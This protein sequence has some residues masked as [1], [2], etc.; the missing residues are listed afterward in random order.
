MNDEVFRMK[1]VLASSLSL[2]KV[3]E[4]KEK[5]GDQAYFL[6]Q[7]L[8]HDANYEYISGDIVFVNESDSLAL[9]KRVRPQAL[10]WA[11]PH[12]QRV[13]TVETGASCHTVAL[14]DLH[15]NDWKMLRLLD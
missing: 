9:C 12:D 14:Q 11:K 15:E 1:D 7:L 2:R 6:N 4:T 10:S 3:N 8:V 13:Y 5:G